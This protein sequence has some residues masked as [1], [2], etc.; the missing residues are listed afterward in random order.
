MIT[1]IGCIS[2]MVIGYFLDSSRGSQFLHGA[3]ER[4]RQ[5]VGKKYMFFVGCQQLF[6]F[7]EFPAPSGSYGLGFHA[8]HNYRNHSS[9]CLH[10]FH[11]DVLHLLTPGYAVSAVV[12]KVLTVALHQ[13]VL[14]DLVDHRL[15]ALLHLIHGQRQV[16]PIQLVVDLPGAAMQHVAQVAVLDHR[17]VVEDG[18]GAAELKFLTWGSQVDH[19]VTVQGALMTFHAN[20]LLLKFSLNISFDSRHS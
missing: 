17:P 9:C 20:T 6:L 1:Y 8:V 11:Q 7:L 10:S 15:G 12:D 5:R 14:H 18:S 16:G 2:G 3:I 13:A 19:T 4:G